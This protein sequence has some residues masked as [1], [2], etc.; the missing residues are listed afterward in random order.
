MKNKLYVSGLQANEFTE[1]LN[2][3]RHICVELSWKNTY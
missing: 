1:S 3:I 2:K